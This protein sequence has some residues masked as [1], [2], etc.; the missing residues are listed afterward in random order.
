MPTFGSRRKHLLFASL[1][2]QFLD[3]VHCS[4]VNNTHN[5][6]HKNLI[7]STFEVMPRVLLGVFPRVL[8]QV[9]TGVLY[10]ERGSS[11]VECRT[12]NRASPGSNPPLLPFRRLG[13]F[14]LSIDA[15]V[16]SA[17]SMST[18]L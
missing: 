3:C 1:Q 18:W 4:I 5:T 16:D 2:S 15:P 6:T 7:L 12:R 9:H 8:L 17:A 11:A 10:V 14:V 13:I